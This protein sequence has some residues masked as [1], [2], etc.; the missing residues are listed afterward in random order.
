MTLTGFRQFMGSEKCYD[1]RKYY[2][3][4]Q[5]LHQR[6]QR[7]ERQRQHPERRQRQRRRRPERRLQRW[8]QRPERPRPHC[9]P[10]RDIGRTWKSMRGGKL[11]KFREILILV[12]Q[13][14]ARVEKLMPSRLWTIIRS[15]SSK[16]TTR[17]FSR[18]FEFEL[19]WLLFPGAYVF[20]ISPTGEGVL[21]GWPNH[22]GYTFPG[23][24]TNLDAAATRENGRTYFFKVR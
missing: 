10:L 19:I 17:E 6:R 8:Q 18:N 7:P 2:R 13:I 12:V 24:E 1:R 11:Q 5:H 14:Y 21:P 9:L 22:I 3:S 16:V 4:K 23:L 20:Q 15:T